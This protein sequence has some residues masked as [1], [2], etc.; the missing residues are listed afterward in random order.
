MTYPSFNSG[1]ILNASDMNAVGLWLVT[2][3]D[4]S[5]SAT[6]VDNC[7][8]SNYRNYR[9][10]YRIATSSADP[11]IRFTLRVGGVDAITNYNTGSWLVDGAGTLNYSQSGAYSRWNVV[12][13]GTSNSGNGVVDIIGPAIAANTSFTGNH[14]N[15]TGGGNA[16]TINMGGNHLTATAYDGFTL[17]ASTG[18]FTGRVQVYGYRN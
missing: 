9:I 17:T 15:S 13:S 8:T 5:G 10:V 2:G 16:R 6:S 7:F 4:L 14:T 1:D 18:T 11:E 12:Y 3:K